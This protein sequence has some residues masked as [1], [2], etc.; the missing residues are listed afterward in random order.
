MLDILQRFSADSLT[1]LLGIILV[2][3][4]VWPVLCGILG[5]RRGQAMNGVVQG[6][7]LG[8]L[9][10]PVIL[11]GSRKYE[12]PSCGKRT[13]TQPVEASVLAAPILPPTSLPQALPQPAAQAEP[14]PA[15]ANC[16]KE[17]ADKLYRWVNKD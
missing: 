16:S 15:V 6:L 1:K 12:C 11:L 2:S 14:M 9:A 5:A 3:W 8:P 10:L 17:E 13:L 7:I 4:L